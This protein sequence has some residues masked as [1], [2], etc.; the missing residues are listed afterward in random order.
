M[1]ESSEIETMTTKTQQEE[2][3]QNYAAFKDLL[4]DLLKTDANRFALMHER[5]VLACFDTSRDAM[6]AGRRLLNGKLFSVQE[7]TQRSV[8]LG[9]LSHD[10]ILRPV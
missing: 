9:G 1:A 4:P 2:V 10:R 6:Q 3:D 7:V 5:Q 8:D